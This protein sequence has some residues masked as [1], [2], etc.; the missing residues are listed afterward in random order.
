[1]LFRSLWNVGNDCFWTMGRS[2]GN[3]V[4]RGDQVGPFTALK[5]GDNTGLYADLSDATAATINQLRLSF[6]VQAN[7]GSI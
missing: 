3:F 6:Q 4:A 7:S 5:F 2:D 1:M